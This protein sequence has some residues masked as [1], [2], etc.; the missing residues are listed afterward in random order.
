MKKKGK[1]FWKIAGISALLPLVFAIL[2]LIGAKMWGLMGGWNGQAYALGGEAYLSFFWIFAYIIIGVIALVYYITTKDKSESL[3]LILIPYTLLQFGVEDVFFFF[4][5]G[6]PF[7]TTQMTWLTWNLIPPTLIS[8]LLFS[9]V[10][11]GVGLFIS[12]L[13]GIFVAYMIAR[14]LYHQKW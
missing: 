9:P 14:W 8:Y 12:A 11:F 3:A 6:H 1:H 5:G 2:D 13:L 4:I 10:V 7:W